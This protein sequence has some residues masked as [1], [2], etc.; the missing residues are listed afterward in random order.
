MNKEEIDKFLDKNL[1][2]LELRKELQKSNKDE[3]IVS[4]GLSVYTL[5]LRS[6]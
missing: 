5:L 6:I 3:L 4:Y 1:G 2:E